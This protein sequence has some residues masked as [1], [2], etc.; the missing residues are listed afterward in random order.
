MKRLNQ[1]VMFSLFY[2]KTLKKLSTIFQVFI[3][4][5]ENDLIFSILEGFDDVDGICG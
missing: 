3:Y 2:Q 1:D 4:L 5:S